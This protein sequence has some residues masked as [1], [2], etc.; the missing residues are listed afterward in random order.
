MIIILNSLII[1][2]TFLASIVIMHV[3]QSHHHHSLR[4]RSAGY[5]TS[6]NLFTVVGLFYAKAEYLVMRLANYFV[7]GR[8]NW[9]FRSR[10]RSFIFELAR[11]LMLIT[12]AVVIEPYTLEESIAIVKN[13]FRDH[14][15]KGKELKLAIRTCPCRLAQNQI[16]RRGK[17]YVSNCTDIVFMIEPNAL[18]KNRSFMRF[19]TFKEVI[20]KLHKFE[21]E[22]LVH[23]FMGL[24]TAIY[25]SVFLT[26]CN[27][28]KDL[29]LPLVWHKKK[30]FSFLSKPHNIA[31]VD[32]EKCIGCGNCITRC[33]VSARKIVD[34]KSVVLDHCFG[35]GTCRVTCEGH[36]IKIIPTGNKP[37]Y[38]PEYMIRKADGSS[39]N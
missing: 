8:W 22:G 10:I 28:N 24:C 11:R 16:D 30:N 15:K 1:V 13:V 3:I 34:G 14:L 39:I 35:C 17:E 20:Q 9:F 26:I 29:C 32:S 36:A 18:T 21:K 33:P 25:G 7:M 19:I 38:F 23:N 37:T 12:K 5:L 4:P 31:I 27:C 2:L 6:N